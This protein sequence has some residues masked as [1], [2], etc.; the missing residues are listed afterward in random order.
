MGI[1]FSRFGKFSVIILLNILHNPFACTSSPS[2]IGAFLSMH[3]I[4][5]STLG[6]TSVEGS[7][8]QQR[9]NPGE[10][11]GHDSLICPHRKLLNCAL[12]GF[13]SHPIIFGVVMPLGKSAL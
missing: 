11:R 7:W 8:V 5:I 12:M 6:I 3:V 1:D 13:S 9:R 10:R 4:C 2:L